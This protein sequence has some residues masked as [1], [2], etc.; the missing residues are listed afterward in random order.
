MHDTP[1]PPPA[2]FRRAAR[3]A[4]DLADALANARQGAAVFLWAAAAIIAGVALAAVAAGLG[5]I[6]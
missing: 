1:Y 2:A 5:F 3:Q 4:A 6:A